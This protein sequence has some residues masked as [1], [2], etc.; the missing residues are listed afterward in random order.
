MWAVVTNCTRGLCSS[1]AARDALC[2]IESHHSLHKKLRTY[3]TSSHPVGRGCGH[4][5]W[6]F[7]RSGGLLRQARYFRVH[8][9]PCIRAERD[10]ASFVRWGAVRSSFPPRRGKKPDKGNRFPFGLPWHHIGH[11]RRGRLRTKPSVAIVDRELL[12]GAVVRWLDVDGI[13]LAPEGSAAPCG[14]LGARV[15]GAWLGLIAHRPCFPRCTGAYATSPRYVCSFVLP[16]L[17]GMGMDTFCS[18]AS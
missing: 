15:G 17:R 8:K 3:D 6:S 14:G 4:L 5:G 11:H 9:R 13:I 10:H 2:A 16:E 7:L 1:L 12:V 18:A